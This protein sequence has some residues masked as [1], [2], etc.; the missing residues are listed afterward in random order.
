MKLQELAFSSGA[1]SKHVNFKGKILLLGLGS[2]GQCILPLLLRHIV[3]D[4]SQ[5]TILELGEHEAIYQERWAPLGVKYI[6]KRIVKSNMSSELSKHVGRGDFICNVSLN[7]DGVAI[8][9]WCLQNSVLYVD[10]SIERWE[11]SPDETIP[12][13]SKRTLYY[14]H[15]EIRKATAKYKDNGSTCVITHGANPGLV[16]HF[17]KAALLDIA[18]KLKLNIPEPK[19]QAEW[20]SLMQKTGTK[21]VHIAERDTQVV[22]VPKIMNEFVNTWS[23]EGFWAEGRAPAELGWGTHEDK[24]PQNGKTH[25]TGP[26]NAIYLT[27]PGVSKLI[28]SWV[29]LGG[30]YNGYLIQHSEAITISEYFTLQSSAGKALYRPTVHYVYQPAD[31]AIA[32]VHEMRGL[33]LKIQPTTRIAKDEIVGGMDELGV[34]L[35]G[36]KFGA[37]WYGSQLDINE[38]R[39]LVP[40]EN[41]TSIQ[42]ASSILAAMVWAINNPRKGCVEPEELPFREVLAIALPYLG[43]MA[44]IQSD[45][46][47]IKNRNTIYSFKPNKNN[48]WGFENFQVDS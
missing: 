20:A 1:H 34:L 15:A 39:Q 32:S 42:V 9:T 4:P 30:S 10:T 13:M 27:Q 14:A 47:P 43:P 44:S 29:P 23:C 24:L 45:W 17:T 7:I 36:D 18:N 40:N 33:E 38:A 26:Q 48:P 2:V 8:V 12:D 6:A 21:V 16:S 11:D 35:L 41:A 31:V 46:T 28:K 5:I 19:N 3:S 37:W 22:D 25:A